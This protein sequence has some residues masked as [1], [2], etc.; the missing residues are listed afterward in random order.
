[1]SKGTRKKAKSKVQRKKK[2]IIRV[3][4]NETDTIKYN[5]KN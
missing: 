2:I 5:R 3:E 1:M 4:L